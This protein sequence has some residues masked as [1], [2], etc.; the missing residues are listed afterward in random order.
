MQGAAK[1]CVEISP[2][3]LVSAPVFRCFKVWGDSRGQECKMCGVGL[4]VWLCGRGVLAPGLCFRFVR[5]VLWRVGDSRKGAAVA[6][7]GISPTRSRAAF[8]ALLGLP[9]LSLCQVFCVQGRPCSP[10]KSYEK[11]AGNAGGQYS[12]TP[13]PDLHWGFEL[14]IPSFRGHIFIGDVGKSGMGTLLLKFILFP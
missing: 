9:V 10:P 5:S 11:P 12:T 13:V 14:P 2:S 6:A 1:I 8:S 3:S 4:G 7:I